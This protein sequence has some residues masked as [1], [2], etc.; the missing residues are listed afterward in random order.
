[1]SGLTRRGL[2]LATSSMAATALIARATPGLAAPSLSSNPDLEAARVPAAN[3]W[4]EISRSA[5][6]GNLG[7][8]RAFLDDNGS[9]N[10]EIC[11]VLK[12]DAYGHGISILVK[13]VAEFGK[14]HIG[15]AANEEARVVRAFGR[16]AG[17]RPFAGRLIR[18]RTATIEEIREGID[19]GY[20]IEELIGNLELA[21]QA[22]AYAVSKGK[23][24]A[25][26]ICLNSGGMSRNGLELSSDQGMNDLEAITKLPNLDIVAMMTHFPVESDDDVAAHL[27]VFKAQ[28][29]SVFARKWLDE[30]KVK[31]HTAN[32]YTTL[33][34]KDAHLDMVRVGGAFCGDTAETDFNNRPTAF[35][36]PMTFKSRV[37]SI[38]F[39]RQGDTVSYDRTRTLTRDSFLANIPVG[40]S[41]G[42]RRDFSNLAYVLINGH[43]VPIV[44]RVTMNTTMV[45]VTDYVADTIKDRIRLGDEVVLFGKDHGDEIR[46]GELESSSDTIGAEFMTVLGEL[47][48]RIAVA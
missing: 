48:P 23:T 28:T 40:Y 46:Q 6:R 15:F 25:T 21:Q 2:M 24:I 13:E 1:M 12:A 20:E 19:R 29:R 38:N 9:R 7:T 34:V 16:E 31:L 33:R 27:V 30:E 44:G 32:S 45:D 18:L 4:L 11:V 10:T 39:Y 37:A 5:F 41:D 35:K 17:G 8:M 14:L 47:N 43:R 36:R 26:H 22:S 3:A 42:Y